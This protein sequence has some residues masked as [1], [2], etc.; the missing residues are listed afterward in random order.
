MTAAIGRPTLRLIRWSVDPWPVDDLAPLKSTKP[1]HGGFWSHTL[2]CR[3]HDG[4][5]RPK[6][7]AMKQLSPL[8][9]I[10]VFN[11][12][13]NAPLHI[14][15]LM[16]Y[17]PST[18]PNGFVRFKE[19]L[20]HFES[21]LHQSPVFRRKLV[22]V[23]FNLSP[24]YWVEDRGFDLEFHVR[25]IGL[26]SPGDWRQ[27]CILLARLHCRPLDLSR[28]PWDAYVIEGLDQIDGLPEGAFALYMKIHHSAIDGA[29]GNRMVEALHDP[30]PEVRTEHVVDT[31]RGE[32]TPGSPEL[33][34][35]AYVDALRHPKRVYELVRHTIGTLRLPGFDKDAS[36]SHAVREKTRFNARVSSHRVFGA[37]PF[38]LDRVKAVKN[39][40]GDCTLN[41]VVLA[42][43]SGALRRYLIAKRE[44]PASPLIAG[45]P[46]STRT[47][48]QTNAEGG[49]AVAGMRINLRTDVEEPLERLR[50]INADAVASKAYANAIGAR[51]MV[52][53]AES[54]PSSMA[55]LGM[56]V[57][58]AFN[59]S[60]RSP[61]V[62]T[63]VT[64]VPGP[65][66]PM[67]MRG[68]RAVRW[69]GAGCLLDG[70]GLFHTVNS[71]WG[72]ITVAY[73]ACREMMPDPAFYDDCIRESFAE[74]QLAALAA[75][76]TATSAADESVGRTR[77]RATHMGGATK[78]AVRTLKKTGGA[79]RSASRARAPA[80]N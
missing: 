76:E 3:G 20:G 14:S 27:F 46:I 70:M 29:T 65:Q 35:R 19:I 47:A 50:L 38:P 59:L 10:F 53:V 41:D 25:H 80:R 28:P 16:F 64:N 49:N 26:P 57:A 1:A 71:Y 62:H 48:D 55:A 73:L 33:L 22:T 36:P 72:T 39:A 77:R 43:V 24:P 40:A 79:R 34:A 68:A 37:V 17:D 51:R 9:S 21:R 61:V 44:L 56:R 4:G 66:A 8:D 30:S 18:A 69:Y 2:A 13:P 58:A 42:V 31:W 52:N 12:R 54:I 60:I 75:A 6:G 63:I 74:L 15:P 32:P 78:Q 67:Y 23:P 5:R 7:S 45:V 11:E